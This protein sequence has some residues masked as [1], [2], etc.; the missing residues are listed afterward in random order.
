MVTFPHALRKKS[1]NL[2]CPP[3]K[4]QNLANLKVLIELQLRTRRGKQAVETHL[5]SSN[6]SLNQTLRKTKLQAHQQK[7]RPQIAGSDHLKQTFLPKGTKTHGAFQE[8]T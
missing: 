3:A 4:I 6:Q 1:V 8:E 2:P 5:T 7:E